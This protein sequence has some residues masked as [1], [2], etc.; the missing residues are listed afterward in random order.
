[1][2]YITLGG[3]KYP[4]QATVGVIGDATER[5]LQC[6]A[7]AEERAQDEADERGL[8]DAHREKLVTRR[9]EAAHRRYL[10][11]ARNSLAVIADLVN[12]A[13]AREKLLNGKDIAA[14][15]LH[16]PLTAE[17]L[18]LIASAEDLNGEEN[19]KAIAA[20]LAE[21]GPPGEKKVAANRLMTAAQMILTA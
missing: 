15:V 1:M 14:E 16:Y 9:R 13:V 2:R 21:W 17:K 7:E 8:D 11:D 20:E 10:A 3:V 5:L 18:V 4:I 19:S 6:L 12:A